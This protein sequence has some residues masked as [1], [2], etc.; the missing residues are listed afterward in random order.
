MKPIEAIS[1]NTGCVQGVLF[2]KTLGRDALV[3]QA[4]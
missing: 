2:F 4:L 3:S 1:E